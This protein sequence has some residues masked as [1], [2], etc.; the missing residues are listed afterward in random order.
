MYRIIS[1]LQQQNHAPELTLLIAFPM[2]NATT[3]EAGE[4]SGHKAAITLPQRLPTI[5]NLPAKNQPFMAAHGLQPQPA[6]ASD[7]RKLVDSAR[8]NFVHATFVPV[9]GI[10]LCARAHLSKLGT[11]IGVGSR[12][13]LFR[14]ATPCFRAGSLDLSIRRM[15]K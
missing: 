6:H 5:H 12:M 2:R 13:G 3:L 11:G 4:V 15:F 10:F 1:S 8:C 7:C 14:S 9:S